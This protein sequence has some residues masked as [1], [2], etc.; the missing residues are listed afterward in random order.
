MFAPIGITR[1]MTI[2][3]S[4]PYTCIVDR[5]IHGDG[6]AMTVIAFNRAATIGHH[7]M[8]RGGCLMVAI[9]T[10]RRPGGIAMAL[11]TALGTGT[12]VM[13]AAGIQRLPQLI[14][15][16]GIAV[17]VRNGPVV[18]VMTA[19]AAD[20]LRQ[21]TVAFGAIAGLGRSGGMVR[22]ANI[23]RMTA[24]STAASQRLH[25]GVAGSTINRIT[26]SRGARVIIGCQVVRS[27]DFPLVTA[28]AVD[29]VA[30]VVVTLGAAT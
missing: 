26:S 6:T 1:L 27:S 23:G 22:I 18:G 24:G 19:F 29:Q 30:D 20:C 8:E 5:E 14:D 17:G 2:L 25:G 12:G 9:D 11:L 28:E 7:V 10:C 15:L 3:A 4:R 13:R 21:G 16:R